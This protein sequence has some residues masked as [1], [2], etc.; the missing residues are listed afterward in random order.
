MNLLNLP[1]TYIPSGNLRLGHNRFSGATAL[2]ALGGMAPL[3]IGQGKPPQVWLTLPGQQPG[4]PW[5]ELIVANVSFHPGLAIEANPKLV[6][7]RLER[8]TVLT[9]SRG[10]DDALSVLVLDL[11]PLGLDVFLDAQGLHILGSTLTD[12]AWVDIPVA[13]VCSAP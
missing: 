11:R 10:D 8:T 5:R 9:V 1:A 6:V 2:F 13:L 4:T 7:V 3:L 12:S